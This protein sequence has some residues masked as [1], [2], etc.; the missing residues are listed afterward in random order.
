MKCEVCG[1]EDINIHSDG[2]CA[3]M[4]AF[5]IGH[6]ANLLNNAFCNECAEALVIPHI[7]AYADATGIYIAGLG[8]EQEA[9]E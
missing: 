4:M 2:G 6:D 9:D 1:K 7:K 3:V 5:C 8:M